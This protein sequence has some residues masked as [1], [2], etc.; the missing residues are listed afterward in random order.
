MTAVEILGYIAL[1]LLLISAA[2]RTITTLRIFAIAANLAIIAYGVLAAR[3]EV[4]GVGAAI[5]IL[6]VWRL[7]EMRRLVAATRG[8]TAAGSAPISMD[9][10]LPYMR[11]MA[12]PADAVIFRKG[13][14]ADA[15]YFVS[16]GKVRIDEFDIELGEGTL[17]GE[18]GLFSDQK[19]RT[20]T[21]KTVGDASLLVVSAERVQELF[22]QNPEFGFFL[23]GLITRRLAEDAALGR[24]R[25]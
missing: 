19:I 16:H 14:I 8:A 4:A 10:L 1:A 20:A 11:P 9:W 24:R 21:A 13:D 5:L 23:V 7:W 6:N 3:Y 12:L 25:V 2:M 15:M 18:I 17:F 22:Y